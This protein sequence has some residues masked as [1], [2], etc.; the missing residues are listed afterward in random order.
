MRRHLRTLLVIVLTVGLLGLFLRQANLSEVAR[1]IGRAEPFLLLLALASVMLIYV[2]RAIRWQAMLEPIGRAHFV[3]AFRTTVI[4][5]AA[6]ALLPARAGE[7]LRP[8]LLARHE[9][10]SAT[11]TFATIILERVL[12]LLTVLLLFGCFVF[13][14]DPGMGS[15]DPVTYRT[16]KLGGMAAA[17]MS[18]TIL[19]VMFVLAGHPERLGQI[20]Q[21]V[22]LVL[23]ARLAAIVAKLAR[24]FAE[25]LAVLR[26][27]SALL[28]AAVLSLPVWFAI[29]TSIWAVTRA[30]HITMPYTGSFLLV[31]LLTVGVAA[32]T[33]GAVG[34]FHYA[35]RVG[36]TAFFAAS[37]DRA[38]GAAIVL[39]AISFVPTAL[40][41]LLFMVQDGLSLSR[42]R[43]MSARPDTGAAP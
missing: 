21:K 24:T 16:V 10:L 28:R 8:Y 15:V 9:G 29:T 31:A 37:N 42:I 33:P 26:H 23:P 27:P 36:A 13:L 30:F 14:F 19:L 40:L 12:D 35:Y 22:E 43:S 1:E 5:F 7:F 6:N 4:G 39:H 11:A 3:P 38:V 25:G 18:L 20:V 41:G 2:F 32:P 17:A 34:G